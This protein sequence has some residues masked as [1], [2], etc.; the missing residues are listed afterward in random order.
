M[1]TLCQT[2]QSH[3]KPS[4]ASTLFHTSYLPAS[5]WALWSSWLWSNLQKHL[6]FYESPNAENPLRQKPLVLA[7]F[8]LKQ[9][10][11]LIVLNLNHITYSISHY[12]FFLMA[13]NNL[14]LSIKTLLLHLTKS[15]NARKFCFSP[16]S[17]S[18]FRFICFLFF[19]YWDHC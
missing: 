18:F 12:V 17:M 9:L 14:W 10:D 16:G 11:H 2:F 5:Q 15:L 4:Q 1:S 3:Y 8:Y 19:A 7:P 13:K 6:L